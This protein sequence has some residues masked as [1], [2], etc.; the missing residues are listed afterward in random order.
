[1]AVWIVML[2]LA[3]GGCKKKGEEAAGGGGGNT[4]PAAGGGNA[5]KAEALKAAWEA[6]ADCQSLD[7]C[8]ANVPGTTWESSL[9]II[10][11]QVKTYKN[12]EEQAKN[13]VDAAWQDMTCKNTLD[14]AGMMGNDSNPVPEGCKRA[15]P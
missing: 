1:M 11:E 5:A 6:N 7:K 15:A 3:L 14:S 10:C 13:M 9:G 12:F 4:P 2:A 8:C